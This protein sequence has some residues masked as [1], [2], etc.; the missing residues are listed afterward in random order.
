LKSA[1]FELILKE[2]RLAEYEYMNISPLLPRAGAVFYDAAF[3]Q[4]KT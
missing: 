4:K 2:I 3:V 1:V